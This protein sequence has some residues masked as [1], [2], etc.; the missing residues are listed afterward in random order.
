MGKIKKNSH[1]LMQ[2]YLAQARS[3]G[4]E[5]LYNST[6]T[7]ISHLGS[8]YLITIDS[9]D[10]PVE[11]TSEIVINAAGL[12]GAEVANLALQEKLYHLHYCKGDYFS[13]SSK[14]SKLVSH[15]IYPA[16]HKNIVGLGVHVTLDLNGQMRL[17]PDTEYVNDLSYGIA[18][19]K[20]QSFYLG[21]K[22]FLP[23]LELDDLNP[24]FSG[25]RPKIQGPK[26][27][28]KDFVIREEPGLPGMIN[29]IGIES[30]GL[31]A[32]LAIARYVK[33]IIRN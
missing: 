7:G 12:H 26:G 2:Y 14:K 11:F 23:F 29:L 8:G 16:P 27:G 13:V 33:K 18:E 5:I 28:F 1:E 31:T 19:D 9:P 32:S 10:G 15:L 6:L 24:D 4:T 3:K 22:R 17:G 21:A 20:R 25:I 30:P